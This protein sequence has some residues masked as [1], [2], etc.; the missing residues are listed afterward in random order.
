[1]QMQVDLLIYN[2]LIITYVAK[3]ISKYVSYIL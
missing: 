3:R 2:T 1:M